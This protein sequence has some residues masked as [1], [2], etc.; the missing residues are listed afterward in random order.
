MFASSLLQAPEAECF[1]QGE[2]NE[3][4]HDAPESPQLVFSG[5]CSGERPMPRLYRAPDQ[6]RRSGLTVGFRR[7]VSAV[8]RKFLQ[9]FAATWY[10][11]S[12]RSRSFRQDASA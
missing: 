10:V 7:L 11:I 2:W 12:L 8:G 6:A 1:R 3:V 4:E 5:I 9:G